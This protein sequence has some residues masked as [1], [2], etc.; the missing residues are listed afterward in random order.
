ME[1]RQFLKLL[2]SG[3]A[4]HTLDIDRLLWIPEQKTIFLPSNPGLSMAEI[5]AIELE[6]L[7]PKIR[8]LFNRDDKFYASLAKRLY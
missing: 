3:V 7:V 5:L 6:R 1:R 2:L 4:G 8:E